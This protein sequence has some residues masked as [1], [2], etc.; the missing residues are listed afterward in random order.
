MPR[1]LRFMVLSILAL[2]P[3]GSFASEN[4]LSYT[5]FGQFEL[6]SGS[7]TDIR[8]KL[9]AAE[10]QKS[11]EAGEYMERLC[12]S[13]KQGSVSFLAAEVGGPDALTGIELSSPAARP[14]CVPWPASIP[15]PRLT[16][17]GIYVGMTKTEFQRLLPAARSIEDGRLI[18]SFESKMPYTS[19]EMQSRAVAASQSRNEGLQDYWDVVVSII[20]RFEKGRLSEVRVWKTATN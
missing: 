19:K 4:G 9:G 8:R 15:Q 2:A 14:N 16:I 7:L 1:L 17:S 12:Y 5:K 20:G 3:P 13:V 11:G 18:V 6:G 10:I